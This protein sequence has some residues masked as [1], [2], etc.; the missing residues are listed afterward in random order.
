MASDMEAEEE[1]PAATEQNDSLVEE[2][3]VRPAPQ[4]HRKY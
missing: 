2:P 4:K 3:Y 1:E